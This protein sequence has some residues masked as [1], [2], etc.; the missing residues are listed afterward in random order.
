M[1]VDATLLQVQGR[2]NLTRRWLRLFRFLESF[3]AGWRAYTAPDKTLDVWLDAHARTCFGMFGLLESATLPDLLA[4]D[5]LAVWGHERAIE[6]NVEAQRFWFIA[7]FLSTLAAGTRLIRG[8]TAAAPPPPAKKTKE[9]EEKKDVETIIKEERKRKRDEAAKASSQ[10]TKHL[11]DMLSSSLD[12]LIPASIL[13]WVD[14]PPVVVGAA[15]FIT[16]LITGAAVWNRCV[17]QL[18]QQKA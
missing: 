5:G 4:V 9:G 14:L 7:L 8:V 11:L 13:G 3:Q 15:M 17:A 1:A 2:L 16:S 18:E 12:L 6:I 10:T